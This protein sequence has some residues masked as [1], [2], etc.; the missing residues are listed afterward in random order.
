MQPGEYEVMTY[1]G[2]IS[3]GSSQQ[4]TTL[5]I[6][7]EHHLPA[8]TFV[9]LAL[10]KRKYTIGLSATPFR[11]DGREEYV[12][13]LTGKPVGLSWDYFKKLNLIKSPTSHV[14]I[15]KNFEA[16]LKRLDSLLQIDMRTII[17][18][19]SLEVGKAISGRFTKPGVKEVP[20]VYGATKDNMETILDRKST[21]LNSSH[22][23]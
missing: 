20:F 14:W 2:A 13:A 9:K 10:L 8:N 4:W 22:T 16:K 1:Q 12:F 23:T 11:E 5:I 17:F 21:R 3:K 19:D 6:D 18:S 7:E 15:V